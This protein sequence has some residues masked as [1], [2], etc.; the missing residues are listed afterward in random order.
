MAE[1]RKRA[2]EKGTIVQII[3]AVVDVEFAENSIPEL[4]DALEVKGDGKQ[5]PDI[6]L[7]VQQQIGGGYAEASYEVRDGKLY[8]TKLI[9]DKAIHKT[10]YIK[11]INASSGNSYEKKFDLQLYTSGSGIDEVNGDCLEVYPNP[12]VSTLYF[13]ETCDRVV[14]TDITGKQVL[15]AQ[16]VESLDMSAL[17]PGVYLVTV[18]T[19]G[20]HRTTQIVKK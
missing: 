11:A 8:T 1:L 15:A 5:R 2:G 17:A 14:V 20:E 7:E 10:V 19:A 3:G 12:V 16:Q 9:E 4:Y 13:K 6:V 18:Q